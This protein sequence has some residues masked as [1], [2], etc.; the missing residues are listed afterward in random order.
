LGGAVTNV[1]HEYNGPGFSLLGDKGRFVLPP[2]FR[3]TLKDSTPGGEKKLYLDMH[4]YFPCL[5]GFGEPYKDVLRAEV[6][7]DAADAETRALRAFQLYSFDAAPFDDSGR[8]VMPRNMMELAGI[9]D[10]VYFHGT[11]PCFTLWNPET[12][13][14]MKDRAFLAAQSHCRAQMALAKGRKA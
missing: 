8:F 11:G 7:A 9:A 13:L 3:K 4:P 5:V 10:A 14:G 12:L 2:K 1:V 6:P